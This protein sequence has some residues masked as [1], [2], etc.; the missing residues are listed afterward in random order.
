MCSE[1]SVG[2]DR[3]SGGDDFAQRH[4]VP[5]GLLGADYRI[6]NGRYRFKK[7]YGCLNWNLDLRSPLL[8]PGVNVRAGGDLIAVAGQQ[9]RPPTNVYSLFWN[10][11]DKLIDITVEPHP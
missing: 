5:G 3:V 1:L 2:H 9:L 6:E 8:E 10:T 11:A 4:A 7:V